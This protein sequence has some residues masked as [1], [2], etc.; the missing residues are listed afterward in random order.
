MLRILEC[1]RNNSLAKQIT[2]YSNAHMNC[3]SNASIRCENT[4]DELDTRNKTGE[5][6]WAELHSVWRDKCKTDD[7]LERWA[8]FI[9]LHLFYMMIDDDDFVRP[10]VAHIRL[11]AF[12]ASKYPIHRNNYHFSFIH[13]VTP[14]NIISYLVYQQQILFGLCKVEKKLVSKISAVISHALWLLFIAWSMKIMR[15]QFFLLSRQK[16]PFAMWKKIKFLDDLNRYG[17]LI[18]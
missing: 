17:N 15:F 7:T 3:S 10:N 4:S 9:W 18:W 8:H 2:E 16:T 13:S 12:N 6:K 14:Q 1:I 5:K 11:V